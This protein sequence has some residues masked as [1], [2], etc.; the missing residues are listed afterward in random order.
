VNFTH[1]LGIILISAVNTHGAAP[2][3]LGGVPLGQ[4]LL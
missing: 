4:K 3:L 2:T 1:V